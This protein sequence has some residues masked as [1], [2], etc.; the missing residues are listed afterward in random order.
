MRVLGSTPSPSPGQVGETLD[1]AVEAGDTGA[2]GPDVG[3]LAEQ[4]A[5]ADRRLPWYRRN[6]AD[7]PGAVAVVERFYEEEHGLSIDATDP[8]VLAEHVP[9]VDAVLAGQALPVLDKTALRERHGVE[10]AWSGAADR[11]H[12]RPGL[13]PTWVRDH[14]EEPV[15]VNTTSGTTGEPWARA[16]TRNDA[17]V[18]VASILRHLPRVFDGLGCDPAETRVANPWP[19]PT[20]RPLITEAFEAVGAE[21]REFGYDDVTAGGERERRAVDA[22][23]DHLDGG[24][25]AALIYPVRYL[26]EGGLGVAVRRGR[27]APDAV[28]TGGSPFAER[29]ETVLSRAGTRIVDV[30]GETEY[31]GFCFERTID[32]T[33]GYEL[34]RATQLNLVYDPDDGGLADEGTGRFAYFPFGIEG[35]A[36]PGV[37]LSGVRGRLHR[38]GEGRQLL[39]DVERVDPADRGCTAPLD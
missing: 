11:D 37:Y 9:D 39:A 24:A 1:R 15:A 18:L 2:L 22:V 17:A 12:G 3:S 6:L 10:G 21:V 7:A 27:L 34:P 32:G 36:V 13:T 38:V 19:E 8:A 16:L 25:H 28:F 20:T 31:P 33:T 26:L 29:Q 4:R 35:Q 14:D 30:F 5:L 23:V